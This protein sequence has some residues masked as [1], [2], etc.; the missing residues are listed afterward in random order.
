MLPKSWLKIEHNHIFIESVQQKSDKAHL[1]TD[2]I[3]QMTE[4][5]IVAGDKRYLI[6]VVSISTGAQWVTSLH[7]C[8]E[9]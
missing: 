4:D 9:F 3:D 5:S 2:S 6:D 7:F 8:P 1:I